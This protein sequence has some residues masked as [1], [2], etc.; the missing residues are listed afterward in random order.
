MLNV[1]S[2][3]FVS[4]RGFYIAIGGAISEHGFAHISSA[5]QD[6]GFKCK[7][8]D[9]SDDMAMISVQGPKRLAR[10]AIAV[11]HSVTEMF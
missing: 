4:G 7:L 8:T 2:N 10:D 1:E 3:V 5:L 9:R 11:L 6:K